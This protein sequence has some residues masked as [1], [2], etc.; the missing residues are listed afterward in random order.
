[1]QGLTAD[2]TGANHHWAFGAAASSSQRWYNATASNDNQ[3]SH[4]PRRA[5][6]VDKCIGVVDHANTALFAE[7]DF[8]SMDADGFTI[9]WTTVDATARIVNYL[10]IGGADLTNVF[11]GNDVAPGA[12]GA[13]AY[14]G[15][16][17]QPDHLI[18]TT[19]D[20][21]TAA[22]AVQQNNAR[23]T[24]GFVTATAEMVTTAHLRSGSGVLNDGTMQGASAIWTAGAALGGDDLR[25]SLD[26]FDADGFT[27]DFTNLGGAGGSHIFYIATKG[28]T[29]KVGTLTQPTSTGNQATT[30][31][32]ITPSA[33][34]LA[35]ANKVTDATISTSLARHSIGAATSAT[36]R[37]AQSLG[38]ETPSSTVADEALSRTKV[39]QM[40]TPGTPTINAAAD[41]VSLDSD[42]FTLNWTTADATQR[43]VIYWA[44]GA[45]PAAGSIL[46][47]VAKDMAGPVD[48]K[49]MRG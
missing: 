20:T 30:G 4:I 37:W 11:V 15:V 32:G 39:I 33:L 9:N 26:S 24:I 35:S 40:I 12:T 19:P 36:A 31:L 10:A 34:I 42:G 16:G 25:A 29:V 27:L 21:S 41:L 28:A 23:P 17:F 13:Q 18:I 43:E 2:G 38:A 1:M 6:A 3:A 48:M 45:A 14:T 5:F 8:V 22:P 44:I 7:A 49:D 46:P 47:F